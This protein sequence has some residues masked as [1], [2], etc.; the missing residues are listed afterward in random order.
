MG[1]TD[2]FFSIFKFCI[3]VGSFFLFGYIDQMYEVGYVVTALASLYLYTLG[4]KYFAPLMFVVEIATR[5]TEI[6]LLTYWSFVI[7]VAALMFTDSTVEDDTKV[8]L[9][10]YEKEIRKFLMENDTSLLGKVDKMLDENKGKEAQLLEKLQSD[11]SKGKPTVRT[12]SRAASLPTS[13]SS[14]TTPTFTTQADLYKYEIQKLIQRN[15]PELLSAEQLLRNYPGRER[16]LLEELQDEYGDF[17]FRLPPSNKPLTPIQPT[18]SAFAE[19]T[20]AP[21]VK[22]SPLRTAVIS[23]SGGKKVA[24]KQREKEILE[25]ARREAREAMEARI[26]ARYGP[27][28]R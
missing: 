5:F 15:N 19:S 1:L 24:S 10:P 2:V 28:S 27:G 25:Q 3:C 18:H 4:F 13:S 7:L 16:E 23:A 14:S 8:K 17:T 20:T 21:T 22:Q 6:K 12:P 11:Y 9:R 26:N